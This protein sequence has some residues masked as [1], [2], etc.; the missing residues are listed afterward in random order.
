M[1]S[2]FTH[3]VGSPIGLLYETLPD[4]GKPL[5]I[6]LLSCSVLQDNVILYCTRSHLPHHTGNKLQNSI[7]TE[8]N[9]G[10]QLAPQYATKD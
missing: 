10:K 3:D 5:D 2:V 9:A 6:Q 8:H 7:E 4:L 1:L